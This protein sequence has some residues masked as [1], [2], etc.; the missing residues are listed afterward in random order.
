MVLPRNRF[1]YNAINKK[2][3]GDLFLIVYFLYYWLISNVIDFNNASSSELFGFVQLPVIILVVWYFTLFEAKNRN[4]VNI[5]F[6]VF[7]AVV[8]LINLVRG[9]FKTIFS[10]AVDVL[11]AYL[12]LTNRRAIIKLPLINCLFVAQIIISIVTYY[13]NIN[14]YGFI[15]GQSTVVD[16]DWKVSLFAY[17]TPPFTSLF[18]FLVF[19]YNAEKPGKMKFFNIIIMVLAVYFIV[20]SGSRTVYL[21]CVFYDAFKGIKYYKKLPQASKFYLYFPFI[22]II[23]I[24]LIGQGLKSFNN[25]LLNSMFLRNVNSVAHYKT[26]QDL[27]RYILW[28]EYLT[29]FWDNWVFGAGSET[30]KKAMAFSEIGK[31]ET[32]LPLMLAIHGIVYFIFLGGMIKLMTWAIKYNLVITYVIVITFFVAC[33]FYGSLMRGYNLVWLFMFTAIASEINTHKVTFKKLRIV[34]RK[35]QTA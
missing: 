30:F 21:V 28:K 2:L 18:A 16:Y 34:K 14:P 9:D 8:I 13:A 22:F 6:I 27:D 10:T 12:I 4:T 25:D 24:L 15:S 35:L 17:I 33:S 7:L 32:L 29:I 11:P 20:F 19:L 23:I 31:D 26:D 1:F 5:Y 3:K